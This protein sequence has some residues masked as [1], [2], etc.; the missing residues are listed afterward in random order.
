MEITNADKF[1]KTCV[2]IY[3]GDGKG[4]TTA[5]IGLAIRAAGSGMKVK[6]IQFLKSRESSEL[7]ILEKIENITIERNSSKKMPFTFAM[8]DEEKKYS[9]QLQKVLFDKACDAVKN[10]DCDLLV[11]DEIFAALSTNMLT[12][13][14]VVEFI[15]QK[16]DDLEIVLTGRNPPQEI[17]DLADYVSEI[18]KIKHPYDKG[19]ESRKG[20]E[21]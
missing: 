20:I 14:E 12:E 8:N 10:H 17:I 2:Q 6:I 1:P 18:K 13:K 3:C 21:E 7:A 4:K 11:L 16:P 19:M 5:A 9:Q 15:K